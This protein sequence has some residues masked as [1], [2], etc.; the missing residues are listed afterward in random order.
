MILCSI[1]AAVQG[2]DQTGMLNFY[3]ANLINSDYFYPQLILSLTF[4]VGSNGANLS[5]PDAFGVPDED[6]TDPAINSWIVGIVNSA[7]YIASA[8]MY[9]LSSPV[10]YCNMLTFSNSGCWLSDPANYYLGRRGTIFIS[11]VFCLLSVIGSA[12][13]QTWPQLFVTRL[14]LGM[15]MGCKASTVPIYSA[16]NAPASIRGA[17]V[18]S[19]QMWASRS[20]I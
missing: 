9:F 5:W 1:G 18:M 8:L 20:C 2:W 12:C 10:S 17:L 4:T 11:A 7:P 19:W 6:P 3:E 14:L 16:E 15:G 13:S